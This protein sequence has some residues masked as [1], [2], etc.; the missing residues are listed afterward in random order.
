MYQEDY[1]KITPTEKR[2]IIVSSEDQRVA[3]R[4]VF[5]KFKTEKEFEEDYKEHYKE[6]KTRQVL[7][8]KNFP[9]GLVFI[10]FKYVFICVLSA[11][12]F[13]EPFRNFFGTC[14]EPFRYVFELVWNLFES[15]S[16][17]V[18]VRN[19]FQTLLELFSELVRNI[20]RTFVGHVS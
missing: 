17:F 5:G 9:V 15:V 10:G 3:R 16:E 13:S 20:I 18:F 8:G 2:C 14:S 1:K 12:T 4:V 19:R 6:E 7:S 11:Y